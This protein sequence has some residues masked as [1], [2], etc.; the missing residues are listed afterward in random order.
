MFDLA[1]EALKIAGYFDK[2]YNLDTHDMGKLKYLC[3][4]YKYL[5]NEQSLK[6]LIAF[7]TDISDSTL[8]N[9]FPSSTNTI[10]TGWLIG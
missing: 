10:K 7:C 6:N 1:F 8:F 2:E 5:A 9:I 3:M 4:W